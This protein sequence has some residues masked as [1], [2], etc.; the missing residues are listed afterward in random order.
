[1][2][3]TQSRSSVWLSVIVWG[4][5]WGIFEAT[6]GYLLH[7]LPFSVGW[8]V[9][10]PVA[11]FFMANVYRRTG[12]V[13]SLLQVGFLAAGIKL[14]NLFLPGRID[15]VIN[16]AVSIVFEALSMA[17]VLYAVRRKFGQKGVVWGNALSAL[18]M[19]TGWRLLYVLYLAFLVPDWMRE[20]SVI[21]SWEAFLPFFLLHNL[22]TSLILFIGSL[23]AGPVSAKITAAEQRIAAP[24]ALLSPRAAVVVK[25]ASA[26][27]LLCANIALTMLL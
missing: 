13:S 8:L 12:K 15:K 25:A 27:L 11:C 21:R 26:A 19:N 23:L 6:V 22:A 16:P 2:E 1:M 14:L 17:A 20:V 9:W 24:F 10:Y 5:L 18:A 7:L 4:S 3:R